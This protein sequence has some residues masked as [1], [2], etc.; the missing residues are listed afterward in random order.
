MRRL[1]S[2]KGRLRLKTHVM[3]KSSEG[4][5]IFAPVT[6][7]ADGAG[8]DIWRRPCRVDASSCYGTG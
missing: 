8:D 2:I 6:R 4:E 3:R 5:D 1:E 7:Y